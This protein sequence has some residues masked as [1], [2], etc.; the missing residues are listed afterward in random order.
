MKGGAKIYV[1]PPFLRQRWGH[2]PVGPPPLGSA[3]AVEL[4][5]AVLGGGGAEAAHFRFSP[6][7]F[8]RAKL[9]T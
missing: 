9:A 6:I 5:R 4:I 8:K 1:G 7:S 2:G 3:L